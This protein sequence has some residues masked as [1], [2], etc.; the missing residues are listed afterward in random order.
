MFRKLKTD[1]LIEL[2]GER[3]RRAIAELTDFNLTEQDLYGYEKG[4]YQPTIKKMPYLLKVY[5]VEYQEISE[6]IEMAEV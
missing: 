4:N 5:N 1:K 2:R 6:P 3:S